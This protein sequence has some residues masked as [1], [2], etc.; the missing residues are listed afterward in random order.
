MTTATSD[1]DTKRRGNQDFEFPV[2]AA[3]KILA[4]TVVVI[5]TAT[6]LAVKGSTAAN[7]KTVGIAQDVA[8]NTSG[9]NGDIRVKVK[10]GLFCLA[11]SVAGDLIVLGDVGS[12]AYLVDDQT[13]A[14]TSGGATRSVAGTIRDVNSAGVWVEI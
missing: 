8:D 3:S 6:N 10:R 13:V 7:L 14:K 11:N 1:R 9:A 5:D 12:P 2:K 4:G